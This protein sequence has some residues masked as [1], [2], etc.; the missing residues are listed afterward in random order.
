[1]TGEMSTLD[2]KDYPHMQ[3]VADA[4]NAELRPFD[5]YQGPYISGKGFKL[6]IVPNDENCKC[7]GQQVYAG[8]HWYNESNGKRSQE[9]F[10]LEDHVEMLTLAKE[11]L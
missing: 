7:C 5:Q 3:K 10:S 8:Y 1:M 9:I 11:T 4:M 2:L 6:W